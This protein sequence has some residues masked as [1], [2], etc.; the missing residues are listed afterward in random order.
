MTFGTEW[1]TGADKAESKKIFYRF[2]E[3]GGNFIDTANRYTEGTSEKFLSDF[4]SKERD[5]FVVATKYSL[6]TQ[7]GDLNDAGNSRKNLMR[8]VEGS[9]KRLNSD[10]IDILYLHMWDFTTPFDEILRGL[11]DLVRMGKVTYIAISDTPAWIVSAAQAIAELRGWSQF[12]ALQAEY[13]LLKRDAERDLLPMCDH[14]DITLTSWAP[15]AGG[16]L[17]GKYLRDPDTIGRVKPESPRRNDKNTL[18]VEKVVEIAKKLGA[19]AT[20]V[21]LNW[22]RQNRYRIIPVIGARRE[23][24]IIDSLG[25]LTFELSPAHLAELDEVSKIDLGFPHDFLKSDI[26]KDLLGG[27]LYDK[28]DNHRI[29]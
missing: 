15:I 10:Y 8:S 2:I 29:K 22:H 14:F 5:R 6:Y 18:I 11:D 13:H 27:G 20:Q 24:Q 26:V 28:Y 19:S 4:I 25:C 23:S 16:V 12:V 7:K 17:S 3:A 1:G 21:A 9:L